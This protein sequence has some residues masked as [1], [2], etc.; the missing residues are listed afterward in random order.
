MQGKSPACPSFLKDWAS[1]SLL[2]N[3]LKGI[4]REGHMPVFENKR[5]K[6]SCDLSSGML[7]KGETEL[8]CSI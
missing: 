1:K 6:K 2:R 7:L 4:S 8:D 3:I 5:A